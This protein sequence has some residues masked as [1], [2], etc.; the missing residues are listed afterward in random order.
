MKRT[1]LIT[2]STGSWYTVRF[3]NGTEAEARIKGKFRLQ[4]IKS[5]NPIAVGDRVEIEKEGE[6]SQAELYMITKLLPR[7]NY[8]IRK[9]NKLSKQSQI[10]AANIDMAC[11]V[12][13]L[14]EPRTSS[15]FIDRFL[16]C[17]E[18]FHIPVLLVF[19]KADLY[20]SEAYELFSEVY[21]RIGYTCIQLSATEGWG[22]EE[23][24]NYIQNKTVLFSG[25][26]GV[27]KST[28]LNALVPGLNARVGNI[29]AA[30]GKGKH[31]TTFAEMHPLPNGGNIIDTPGI[32][33]FGVIDIPEAEISHYF[34]EMRQRLRDCK[35]NNCIHL[36]EP[37]CEILAC[38]RDGIIDEERYYNY[39]SILRNEDILN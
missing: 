32:R 21:K 17:A 34:P 10:I 6:E 11:L 22:L 2:K 35:F 20:G 7:E 3:D 1:G 9:S 36:N 15:G 26:S 19:N 25:H 33:D 12:I 13:S 14:F 39:L 30:T 23:L 29:S 18:A 5:T 37:G 4:G 24:K 28:L 16:V 27:G 38:V 31:T 8:I